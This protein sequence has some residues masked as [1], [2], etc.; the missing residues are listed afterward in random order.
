MEQKQRF[1]SVAQSGYFTVT[2]LC[3]EF[4]ISRKT[5]H[6]WLMRYREGGMKNLEERSRA[7]KSVSR[8]TAER[9]ERFLAAE[10]RKHP[11][12]GPKKIQRILITRYA[13]E[14]PP[15]VSTLGEV[16]KRHGM[17][18][19]RKR[20]ERCFVAMAYLRSSGWTMV[21]PL[22]QWDLAD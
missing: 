19:E 15:V 20:F 4:G 11:T 7:S 21:R 10:K 12:W 17:V 16:L 18:N 1:V 6:K 13:L 8:W 9:I 2:E 14:N 22:H 5:G 3:A